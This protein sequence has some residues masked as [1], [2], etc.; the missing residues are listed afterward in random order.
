VYMDNNTNANEA[1]EACIDI[2]IN[3]TDTDTDVNTVNTDADADINTEPR[4]IRKPILY[5]RF[6]RSFGFEF[7]NIIFLWPPLFVLW[8]F[9][10]YYYYLNGA[11]SIPILRVAV[12]YSAVFA[13]AQLL[14]GNNRAIRRDMGIVLDGDRIIRKGRGAIGMLECSDIRGVRCSQN[15]LFNKKMIIALAVGKAMLPLNLSGSYRMV[16]VILEK[17]TAGGQ[18]RDDEKKIAGARRRLYITA[19]QYNALYR[20]RVK[21]LQSFIAVLFAAAFLNGAVAAMYWESGLATALTWGFAGMLFQT[22]GYLAAERLW[23]WRMY[24]GVDINA[25]K[26]F[27]G[28]DDR[29]GYDV[30]K[31]IH[32]TAAVTALLAV[33]VA[34]ILIIQ[35]TA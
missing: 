20:L 33:M 26:G 9:V 19:L 12:C 17:I 31:V 8:S 22:V 3:T 18:L 4:S 16:E 15:P 7:I 1:G 25:V 6:P 11:V 34:G 10:A 24:A 23:A 28:I 27:K 2:D 13:V 5:A 29:E 35:P 14:Y 30:F 21:H 32:A